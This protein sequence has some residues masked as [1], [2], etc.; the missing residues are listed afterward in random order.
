M[1]GRHP[2][3]KGGRRRFEIVG[4]QPESAG[5]DFNKLKPGTKVSLANGAEAE[6]VANPRDGYWIIVRYLSS[7][8]DPSLV[9]KE[10]P[11][12]YYDL[13]GVE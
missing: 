10:E 8:Q 11:V 1:T 2:P 5:I 7:P 4:A 3:E 6:I 13:T 9:G 12:M